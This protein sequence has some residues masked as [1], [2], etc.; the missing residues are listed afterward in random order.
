MKSAS[1]CLVLFAAILGKSQTTTPTRLI[2]VGGVAGET[3]TFGFMNRLVTIY[4]D[5]NVRAQFG[6]TPNW[7]LIDHA[8][9]ASFQLQGQEMRTTTESVPMSAAHEFPFCDA[10][11]QVNI[12]S[13]VN[14]KLLLA[15]PRQSRIKTAENLGNEAAFLVVYAASDAPI[16]YETRISLLRRDPGGKYVVA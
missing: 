6:G 3:G 14:E 12:S 10:L 4:S 1:V 7:Q 15:L 5:G 11:N 13:T 9:S 16:R 2:Y 8:N